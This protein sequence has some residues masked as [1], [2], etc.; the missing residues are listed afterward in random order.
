MITVEEIHAKALR[1]Y[2]IAVEAWLSGN[3][4]LF[5]QRMRANL[6]I[7]KIH[8]E[9]SKQIDAIRQGSKACT[10]SGYSVEWATRQ[11]KVHGLQDVP[12]A[13]VFETFDDL[14]ALCGKQREVRRLSKLANR[15]RTEL[16]KLK[17]WVIQ[18]WQRILDIEPD[19]DSMIM[20][21]KEMVARPR[22]NCYLRE[23]PLPISTKLI[24][25]NKQ[26][27]T[28]W[29]DRLL[30]DES[31][32]PS[33]HF[34][35]RYGFRFER[36]HY[37]LRALD[38]RLIERWQLPGD[39]ISLPLEALGEL[40]LSHTRL[41]LVEN[42]INILTLPKIKRSFSMGGLGDNIRR[43]IEWAAMQKAEIV[44]WGDIDVEGFE[45]L[46]DLRRHVPNAISVMMDWS[47]LERFQSLCIDGKGKEIARLD[48]LYDSEQTALEWCV[49]H[50]RRLEQERLPQSYI[51]E[52]LR[53]SLQ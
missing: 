35:S 16:P 20:V 23:L 19:I 46:D 25:E 28:E 17:P 50:N 30:P 29:F 9:A 53:L 42:K 37:L 18:H 14:V 33:K 43:L 36:D 21:A 51:N 47:T 38:D 40:D 34:E 6:T 49:K 27:F 11:L 31:I 4:Q 15:V 45:I 24:E 8:S 7:S 5:P 13:I 44:Y 48:G 10:G 52:I 12:Q 3:S 2:P 22:P 1:F 32:G 39:E 41:I 26:L